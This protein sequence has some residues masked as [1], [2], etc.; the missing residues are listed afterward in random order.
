[1]ATHSDIITYKTGLYRSIWSMYESSFTSGRLT[2]TATDR[3]TK[4][5]THAHKPDTQ[6]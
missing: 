5:Y 1:M 3:Q 2:V 4:T 6:E